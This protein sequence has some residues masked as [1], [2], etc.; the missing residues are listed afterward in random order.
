MYMY[1]IYKHIYLQLQSDIWE[2]RFDSSDTYIFDGTYVDAIIWVPINVSINI[3]LFVNL[4]TLM[5]Q[6][7]I[8]F[9]FLRLAIFYG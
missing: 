4:M 5:P 1:C 2:F 6:R 9:M 8:A 7:R 3:S